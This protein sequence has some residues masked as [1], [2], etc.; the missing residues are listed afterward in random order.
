M[1]IFFISENGF[2]GFTKTLVNNLIITQTPT[3]QYAL[4]QSLLKL[5]QF[6][7]LL[8]HLLLLN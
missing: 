2:N 5:Y 6:R 7:E 1:D 8:S 3:Y 4:L